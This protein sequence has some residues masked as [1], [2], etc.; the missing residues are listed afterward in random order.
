MGSLFPRVALADKPAAGGDPASLPC[1]P[2][3]M[4]GLVLVLWPSPRGVLGSQPLHAAHVAI[5][6][7]F[8]GKPPALSSEA[9]V[10]S[11]QPEP[12]SREPFLG[13]TCCGLSELLRGRADGLLSWVLCS[14]LLWWRTESLTGAPWAGGWT[15][16]TGVH[17]VRSSLTSDRARSCLVL[18]PSFESE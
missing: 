14:V 13:A 1:P 11:A 5:R 16:R 8:S 4:L 6:Q 7:G 17:R 18:F 9:G 10:H 2:H 12:P 15:A 3:P